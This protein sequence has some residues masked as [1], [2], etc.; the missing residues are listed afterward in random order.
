MSESGTLTIGEVINLLRDDFPDIS[1]S[2]VRFLESQGLLTPGRSD[3]GYRL[4]GTEDVER[5]RFVLKQ[6]RDHFLPLKV[7]KSRLTLWERGED[8]EGAEPPMSKTD[9]LATGDDGIPRDDLLRKSRLS[10]QDLLE[11]EDHGIIERRDDHPYRPT[12]LQIAIE[13]HRLMEMGLEARHLRVIRRAAEQEAALVERHAAALLS[14]HNPDARRRAHD[15]VAAVAES[16][17][18]MHRAVL[19]GVLQ[20]VVRG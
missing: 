12:D 8:I 15:T 17:E 7:I 10:E 11:L 2:K 6:Q 13:A 9:V 14:M 19:I 20:D 16:L 1:V 18:A 5:L 3:S 4:F